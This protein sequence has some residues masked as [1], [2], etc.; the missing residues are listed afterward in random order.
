M[1]RHIETALVILDQAMGIEREGQAFYLRAAGIAQDHEGQEMFRTLAGEEQVHYDVLK[2]AHSSLSSGGG[3]VAPAVNPAPVNLARQLFPKGAKGL[4]AAVNPET[5]ER[6]ALIFGL[7][8]ESR[9]FDLYVRS[10]EATADLLGRQTFE[11]LAG[12]EQA[13]FDLLMMRF[14]TLFGSVTWQY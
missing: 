13:H 5:S 6:D 9:S 4:Q 14:E 1:P 3:W 2:R 8:I 12:Q 11:S 10:A 7:G